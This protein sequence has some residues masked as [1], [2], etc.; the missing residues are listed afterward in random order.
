MALQFHNLITA[1]ATAVV[2]AGNQLKQKHLGD[3]KRF[4]DDNGLPFMADLKIPSWNFPDSQ[5]KGALTLTPKD[6][7]VPLI[8]LVNTNQLA[9]QQTQISMQV[10]MSELVKPE[11]ANSE[12]KTHQP[13]DWKSEIYNSPI[14]VSLSSEKSSSLPGSAHVVLTVVSEDPPE[15][16]SKLINHL[17]KNL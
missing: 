8:T 5:T 14:M 11:A 4:F 13:F 16:L 15:G 3:L 12:T 6:V 17:N 1:L 7:K 9:I 10:D 2:E